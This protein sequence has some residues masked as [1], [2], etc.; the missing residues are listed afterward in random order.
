MVTDDNQSIVMIDSCVF[1]SKGSSHQS[2]SLM[3][4]DSAFTVYKHNN[5]ISSKLNY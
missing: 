5:L 3:C 1:H 4:F 2:V